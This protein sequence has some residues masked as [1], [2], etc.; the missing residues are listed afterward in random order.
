VTI[1]ERI[2]GTQATPDYSGRVLTDE[3]IAKG[4]HREWVGG[5]WNTGH[6][7]AQLDFLIA[8]GLLPRH[9]LLDVGCGSFRAG[10]HFVDYV[11][12][13]NYYGIDA[14]LSVLQAGYDHEL[15]EPQRLRLPERNLRANDRFDADFGVQF[16]YAIAQ[17]VFSHVSLNHVRLCLYR[18][19]RVMRPG[20][21]FYATFFEQGATRPVDH[22]WRASQAR[23]RFTERNVFWYYRS[24][25]EWAASFAPW[26]TRYIGDW[27][28]P[29]GQRMMQFTRTSAGAGRRDG[30][31]TSGQQLVRR[32]RRWIARQI[33]P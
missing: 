30:A 32:G 27:G 8:H 26:R 12:E 16:D 9:T 31:R 10:V 14:N 7:R 21:L 25:L 2:E 17:S 18:L 19:A 33:A 5:K 4:Q 6:G 20:G 22:I 3:E 11:D 24:D 1:E 28:H 13:G 15:S 23:P 29:A